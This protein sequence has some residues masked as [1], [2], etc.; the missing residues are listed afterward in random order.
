ME[1]ISDIELYGFVHSNR[2]LSTISVEDLSDSNRS[3]SEM[4]Q[5]ISARKKTHS[6]QEMRDQG[7]YTSAEN[8]ASIEENEKRRPFSTIERTSSCINLAAEY[9]AH[10][11]R[12]RYVSQ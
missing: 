3:Q 4:S 2:H 12:K 5:P 6:V 11:E 1:V 7:L 10:P 9:E 8:L